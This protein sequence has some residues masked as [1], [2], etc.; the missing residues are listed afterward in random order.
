MS[1]MR[2]KFERL[3]A[4]DEPTHNKMMDYFR[5]YLLVGGLPVAVIPYLENHNIQSSCITEFMLT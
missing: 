4:L 5:K 2:K 1:A 3:E